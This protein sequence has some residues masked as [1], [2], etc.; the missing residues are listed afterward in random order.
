[1]IFV[2]RTWLRL[3]GQPGAPFLGRSVAPIELLL[4]RWRASG[5]K[6]R[7][8][9]G[10][11]DGAEDFGNGGL[12]LDQGN[13]AQ[14]ALAAGARHINAECAAKQLAPRNVLGVAWRLGRNDGKGTLGL[15]GGRWWRLWVLG[16]H[17]RRG[18]D[19]V[20]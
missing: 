4:T 6:W 19:E 2:G 14:F 3:R 16:G 20:P 1:M 15:F 12:L 8:P 17:C 11:A 18:R 10:V 9:S 5:C 7:R 13:E